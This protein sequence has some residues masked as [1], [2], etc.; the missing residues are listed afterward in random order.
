[1]NGDKMDMNDKDR[2]KRDKQINCTGLGKIETNKHP[3]AEEE[4]HT[5]K[6]RLSNNVA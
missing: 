3:R 2:L 5:A 6:G 4:Q 1:M